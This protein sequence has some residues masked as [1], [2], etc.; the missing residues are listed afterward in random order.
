LRMTASPESHFVGDKLS[1]SLA[2]D[3]RISA[4]SLLFFTKSVQFNLGNLTAEH[5]KIPSKTETNTFLWWTGFLACICD[6]DCYF[7]VYSPDIYLSNRLAEY[8]VQDWLEMEHTLV[9]GME[10]LLACVVERNILEFIFQDGTRGP[11]FRFRKVEEQQSLI[12]LLQDQFLFFPC[13]ASESGQF[14]LLIRNEKEWLE[15]F[16]DASV[17]T[18]DMTEQDTT[19][20]SDEEEVALSSSQEQRH[21]KIGF[22]FP[23]E[24]AERLANIA[25]ITREARDELFE[26]LGRSKSRSILSDLEK[27]QKCA[28][29]LNETA[30][31]SYATRASDDEE[32]LPEF[33]HL[34]VSFHPLNWD[35]FS[36]YR[37]GE[38]RILYSTVLEYVV[39]RSTCHCCKVRRHVWPYLLRVFPW[40]SDWEQR[41][42][43]L[44]EKTRQYRLLKSQ[45]QNILPE[46]EQQF[47]AFRERRDLIEKDVVRTDRNISIYEDN[48]SIATQ[49]MKEILL[50]YSFYNFDVGYCQGMSD[51]LSPILFVFYSCKEEQMEEDE[52]VVFWCFCGLMER[53]QSNFCVDQ[54]GMSKQLAKLKHIVQVF[55]STLANWLA[56]TSPEYLFCFRWL[57]VLFKREF[58]L[59]DVLKLWDVRNRGLQIFQGIFF[60]CVEIGILL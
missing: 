41:K 27:L 10:R 24:V 51:I 21:S 37:D 59:E 29:H 35:T 26:K 38:G 55:D 60:E 6:E 30:Q 18:L 34:E 1:P 5:C 56:T 11:R 17:D 8:K 44:D 39:F 13:D 32:D 31:L 48:N 43:I 28:W 58:V 23:M 20:V 45:W 3:E 42:A 15:P 54:F 22:Q 2:Q 7:L 9:V 53:I 40:N 52:V 33:I 14:N 19:N 16:T 12:S 57:L 50:T 36:S 4:S 49:K 46:Q 25:R 47:R